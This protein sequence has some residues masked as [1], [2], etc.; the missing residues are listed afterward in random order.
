M[1]RSFRALR[2]LAN[3][4]PREGFLRSSLQR[5]VPSH[6]RHSLPENHISS[7]VCTYRSLASETASRVLARGT[8]SV[9]PRRGLRHNSTSSGP[10]QE[11]GDQKK[12]GR[13]SELARKYGWAAFGVYMALSALDFPFCFLA[14]RWIGTKRISEVEEFI[15]DKF[16]TLVGTVLPDVRAKREAAAA[17]VGEP[18]DA[19]KD[20]PA[21]PRHHHDHEGASTYGGRWVERQWY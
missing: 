14:V 11:Q 21:D 13:L 15:V 18:E 8:R 16:W 12:R 9:Q 6:S 20:A 7:G 2:R 17:T 5:D 3:T 19:L 1:L 4:P 10:T